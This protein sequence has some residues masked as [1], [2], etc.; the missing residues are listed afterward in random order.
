MSDVPT[1]QTA[2]AYITPLSTIVA[3]AVT[4]EAKADKADETGISAIDLGADAT[5]AAAV[6]QAFVTKDVWAQAVAGDAV[7]QAIQTKN[8][9]MAEVFVSAVN[10]VDTSDAATSVSRAVTMTKSLA[11]GLVTQAASGKTII[12]SATAQNGTVTTLV[13]AVVADA[14]VSAVQAYTADAAIT[15]TSLDTLASEADALKAF[16]TDVTV[17]VTHLTDQLNFL[18]VTGTAAEGA[19]TSAKSSADQAPTTI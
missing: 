12:D 10:A 2:S 6:V 17:L 5:D 13:D 18:D 19:I 15:D 7:A 4:P 11:A 9:Q 8:V 3:A 14:L 1:A 16:A